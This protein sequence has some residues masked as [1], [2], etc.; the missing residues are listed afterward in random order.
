[1]RVNVLKKKVRPF[2]RIHFCFVKTF[3]RSQATD[4]PLRHPE[5]ALMYLTGAGD[6]RQA[7][8][9]PQRKLDFHVDPLGSGPRDPVCPQPVVLIGL[10]DITHLVCPDGDVLLIHNA[11]LFPLQTNTLILLHCSGQCLCM[12][13]KRCRLRALQRILEMCRETQPWNSWK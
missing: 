4:S 2:I 9:V 10:E 7:V 1:M 5:H 12:Q 3:Y 6:A 11:H 13:V 8:A